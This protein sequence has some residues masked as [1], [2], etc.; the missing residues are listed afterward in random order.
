MLN[1]AI[2]AVRSAGNFMQ[3]SVE[4]VARLANNK[5]T[6]NDFALQVNRIAR[7]KIT[8]I[9]QQA[10]PHHAILTETNHTHQDNEKNNAVS[11][12]YVWVINALD[13]LTNYVH[14]Y[15]QYAVAMALKHRGHIKLTAV[16]DPSK[17][18]LFVA[19]KGGGAILNNRHIRVSQQSSINAALIAT[20]S[21][22]MYSQ[23]TDTYINVLNTL[24]TTDGIRCTGSVVLDLAHLATGRLD[25][26]LGTGINTQHIATSIL[27]VQE[28]G[29]MATDFNLNEDYLKSG[30]IIVGNPK[31]HQVLCKAMNASLVSG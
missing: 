17:D 31:I 12:E 28:A 24:P 25:G 5:K 29:G 8:Q 21:P 16:Y 18:E 9:I 3:H 23:P 4:D 27:L 1:I 10:Y 14:G 26:F 22:C 30:N 20:E 6:K 15:P 2:R 11:D 13:S 7:A 19:E